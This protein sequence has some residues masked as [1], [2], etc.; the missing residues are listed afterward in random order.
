MWNSKKKGLVSS[1]LLDKCQK[2]MIEIEWVHFVKPKYCTSQQNRTS[3][4]LEK[5]DPVLEFKKDNTI[6]L[7]FLTDY[8]C[9]LVLLRV[10]IYLFKVAK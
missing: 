5:V 10:E 6:G 7:W 1:L 9:I 4:R 8:Q 3:L 2:F